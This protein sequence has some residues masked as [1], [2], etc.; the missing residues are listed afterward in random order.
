M[1]TLSLQRILVDGTLLS[2]TMG[3]LILGSLRYNPRLWL[4]DYPKEMRAKVPPLTPQE[5]RQQW[6]LVI[7]FFLIMIGLP[8]GSTYLLRM[9][10]GG[11]IPFLTAY[12]NTA[13]VLNIFN[14]FDAVVLDI[15]IF[16]LMKPKFAALPGT[17][18]M[19]YLY[20]DWGMHLRNYLKGIVVCAVLSAPIAFVATL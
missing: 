13:L 5:K 9:Q 2:L 19:E 14:L 20:R 1:N 3:I 8:L 11:T 6:L 17:E 10:N 4:Q 16:T 12:L 18:G 7:P 15:L